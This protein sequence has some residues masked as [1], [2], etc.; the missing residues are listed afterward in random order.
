MTQFTRRDGTWYRVVIPCA[1]MRDGRAESPSLHGLDD[2]LDLG[3]WHRYARFLRQRFEVATHGITTLG[4]ALPRGVP[5]GRS[6]AREPVRLADRCTSERDRTAGG[7]RR[8]R[9]PLP[10]GHLA[11]TLGR[12]AGRG[13]R[14]P[15]RLGGHLG[16]HRA[17]RDL[18]ADGPGAAFAPDRSRIGDPEPRGQVHHRRA[19]QRGGSRVAVD[20]RRGDDHVLP[21][22]FSQH[23]G[24]DRRLGFRSLLPCLDDP[25][26]IRAVR[27]RH[28]VRGVV[29]G[30]VAVD[31]VLALEA[32]PGHVLVVVPV[33]DGLLE[34]FARAERSYP[35]RPAVMAAGVL[36]VDPLLH[37]FGIATVD[38]VVDLRGPPARGTDDNRV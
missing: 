8:A 14:E 3:Y 37:G 13:H 2:P 18:G 1:S 20:L 31:T 25:R 19:T 30:E 17:V 10:Q 32:V 7:I 34:A 4:L 21:G 11:R 9:T 29:Q 23:L 22:C 26:T 16:I 15:T 24:I 5:L 6:R 28:T 36:L 33:L 27:P 12:T 35:L 38:A